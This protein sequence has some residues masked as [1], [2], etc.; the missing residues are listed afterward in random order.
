MGNKKIILVKV[1][2]PAYLVFI[3]TSLSSTGACMKLSLIIGTMM[4]ANIVMASSASVECIKYVYSDAG[5]NN[6]NAARICSNGASVECIKYVYSDAGYN[7][8]KAAEACGEATVECIKY[9]YSDAGYNNV[10]AAK[11]CNGR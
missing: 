11:A 2:Y 1:T 3:S 9:V 6:A 10:N 7:N 8:A 4:F 5:Y